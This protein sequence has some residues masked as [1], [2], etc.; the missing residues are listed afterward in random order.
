MNVVSKLCSWDCLKTC[1]KSCRGVRQQICQRLNAERTVLVDFWGSKISVSVTVLAW[2]VSGTF[3]ELGASVGRT[4]MGRLYQFACCVSL[5]V[6]CNW[7]EDSSERQQNSRVG[8]LSSQQVYSTLLAFW[9]YNFIVFLE[10]IGG[11]QQTLS[12]FSG[13]KERLKGA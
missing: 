12:Q 1:T 13:T 5:T 10:L 2:R 6:A 3:L 8:T 7:S 9:T 11:V 4:N